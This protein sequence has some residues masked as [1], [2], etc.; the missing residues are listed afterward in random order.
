MVQA[1][2]PALGM[3]RQKLKQME[4][5]ELEPILVYRGSFRTTRAT[6]G[7]PMGVRE[8]ECLLLLIDISTLANISSETTQGPFTEVLDIYN[9]FLV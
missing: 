5:C 1:L 2:F 4:L 7:N 3:Q 9:V 6:Q 8:K